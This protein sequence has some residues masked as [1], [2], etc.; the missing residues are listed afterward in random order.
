MSK[1]IQK[2]LVLLAFVLPF[3]FSHSTTEVYGLIKWVVFELG[4]LLLLVLWL[5]GVINTSFRDSLLP[6][7]S[8][9]IP[10]GRRGQPII[11]MGLPGWAVLIFFSVAILS[12]IKASNIH[13]G[14]KTIY[15]LGAGVGLF[16]LAVNN[17]KQKREVNEIVFA[18]VLVGLI[19]CLFTIYENRGI[20]LNSI[21]LA[22]IS[23]FGNP[24]FFAQYL[25]LAIT[26]SVAMC[27]RKDITKHYF[28]RLFFGLSALFM[29][30]FLILTR[31]RGAYLGLG[32]ALLY[33]YIVIL[34][35]CSKRLRKILIGVLV[36]C[37]LVSSLGIRSWVGEGKIKLRN[38]MRVYLWDATF[39]MVKDY[40]VLGVGIGNFKVIYPIYRTAEERE[41][42]PSGV[43]YSK[44]HNDF[45]QIWAETGTLG[46][47]SFLWILFSLLF[48]KRDSPLPS[49]SLRTG[50]GQSLT[51]F[52]ASA[53]I[54]LGLNAALTALLVQAFFNPLLH[55][56][57]SAMGFWMVLGLLVIKK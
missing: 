37:L 35:Y 28:S 31:S 44:A 27:F 50:R 30:G 4:V 14:I 32:V 5:I 16:L 11:K 40:P 55:A 20:R 47:I 17:V 23:T 46:L 1:V 2:G 41:V 25:T 36:V 8:L 42:T 33:C 21:R 7:T 49:T 22:Y 38:L 48:L 51:K 43:K 56:P 29:L 6:S 3:I 34:L 15:Q 53:H 18:M 54:S 57:A 45:L 19:T 24:I 10:F 52:G 26:L 13:E 9:G 39:Q 12:L